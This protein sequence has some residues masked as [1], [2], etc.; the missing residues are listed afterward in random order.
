M[1]KANGG[2]VR[3]RP[4]RG[5]PRLPATWRYPR[6]FFGGPRSCGPE[7]LALKRPREHSPR[8]TL[9]NSPA[10]ISPEGA[11]RHG[12]NRLRTF[13]PDR[14]R[15]SSPFRAKRLFRVTQG[16][17]WYVFSADYMAR[18]RQDSLAQGLP[19]VSQQNVLCPEGAGGTDMCMWSDLERILAVPN[20][21]FRAYCGGGNS[22]RVN[23]GLSF[24]APSGRGPRTV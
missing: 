22:P 1:E 17:P 11:T 18:R 5:F 21:P 10:R 14:M 20:G 3:L 19:W 7:G 24:L 23:P 8:F 13:E 15:I 9:G 12:E 6:R 4:N 2:R 16:K